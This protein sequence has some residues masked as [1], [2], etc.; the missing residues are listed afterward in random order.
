MK[1]QKLV[2]E[3]PQK[4]RFVSVNKETSAKELTTSPPKGVDHHAVISKHMT[5]S[6]PSL[7][8]SALRQLQRQ[9]GNQYVQR[10][11]AQSQ[12]NNNR[13]EDEASGGVEET[14]GRMR[15]GGQSLDSG[16]R[17]QM[18]SAFATDFSGVRIH[19]N[20]EAHA[21]NRTL[22]ARAFTT[23]RD[24]FFRQGEYSPASTKGQELLA[25]ELTHVVQQTG[26]VQGKLSIG[27]PG[28]VYEKEADRVS[29]QVVRRLNED[30][31]DEESI[32]MKNTGI[33]RV[34]SECEE[35]LQKQEDEEEISPIST[36]QLQTCQKGKLV[37]HDPLP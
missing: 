17:G 10:A 13:L 33:Q 16:I 32:N 1:V 12:K 36:A 23:G 8:G 25:H 11:L 27:K 26:A 4:A 37:A 24:I 9:Y 5:S 20:A 3:E 35:E 34:C 21:L 18:E 7:G 14:I 2:N 6:Q 28:D 22:S 31:D 30:T 15:G 29:R 19:N